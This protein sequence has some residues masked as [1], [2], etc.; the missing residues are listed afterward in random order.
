MAFILALSVGNH[1]MAFLAAPAIV[2]FIL[3]VRP[4]TILNWKLYPAVLAAAV[5]GLSVHLYLP[6]R[7]ALDPMINQ[8]DPTCTGVGSALTA[9]VTYGKYGCAALG[10]SLTRAQF[11]ALPDPANLPRV[12][13]LPWDLTQ[14]RTPGQP[15]SRTNPPIPSSSAGLEN[16]HPR[17]L[18]QTTF[19]PRRL[20]TL[21]MSDRSPGHQ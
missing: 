10:E 12:L 18:N 21:R 17:T 9:I 20:T 2:V 3:F 4:R 6:L 1:L 19:F 15:G 14:P 7:A 8:T 5:V 16:W 13:A 11:T